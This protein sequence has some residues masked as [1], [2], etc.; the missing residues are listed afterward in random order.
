MLFNKGYDGECSWLPLFPASGSLLLG[1]PGAAS[2][3]A[4]RV[5]GVLHLFVIVRVID[6]QTR[7]FWLVKFEW[8]LRCWGGRW[9]ILD[10]FFHIAR[11]V[12]SQKIRCQIGG[13]SLVAIS[14]SAI[15]KVRFMSYFIMMP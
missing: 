15:G 9:V 2:D 11:R 4:S 5:Q 8:L 13:K 14:Q 3:R 1:G 12:I 6:A 10:R 7:P